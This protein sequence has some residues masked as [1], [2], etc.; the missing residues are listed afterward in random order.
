MKRALLYRLA[1][2]TGLRAGELRSLRRRSFDFNR[3]TVSVDAENTKNR[4]QAE[5]PLRQETAVMLQDY[6]AGKLP[7]TEAFHVT[8]KTSKMIQA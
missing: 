7:Q 6:L 1:L 5:L 8:D 4:T 2:E 3:L